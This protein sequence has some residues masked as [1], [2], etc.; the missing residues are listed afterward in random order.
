ELRTYQGLP[1]ITLLK[2]IFHVAKNEIFIF[3][4]IPIQDNNTSHFF[5]I[6]SLIKECIKASKNSNFK[7]NLIS[8]I[9][10]EDILTNKELE[11]LKKLHP[12]YEIRKGKFMSPMFLIFDNYLL[13][14]F[15][16]LHLKKTKTLIFNCKNLTNNYKENFKIFWEKST[17]LVLN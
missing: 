14:V 9:N 8:P 16:N 17:P 13:L 12:R 3:H 6:I 10:P 4:S 1:F 5:Y 11:V 2:Y 15:E 7:L